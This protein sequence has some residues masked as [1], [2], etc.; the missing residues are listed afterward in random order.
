VDRRIAILPTLL[1]LGNAVCGLAAIAYV[2]KVGPTPEATDAWYFTLGAYLILAAMVFDALDGAVARL[3]RTSTPFGA[4]LDSLCDAISFG[5]APA[6]LLLRLGLEWEK[7]LIRQGVA[8][9]AALYMACAILRLARFNIESALEAKR[10]RGQTT[11]GEEPA[12]VNQPKRFKGLPSPAAAGCVAS[13]AVLRAE[14]GTEWFGLSAEYLHAFAKVW[15]PLGTLLVALLMVS[16]IPYPHFTKR[17]LQKKRPF[18][19]VV[20]AVFA[21]FIIALA[22]HLAFIL[23]FWAYALAGPARELFVRGVR[24]AQFHHH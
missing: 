11:G 14:L 4:Q 24:L 7:P 20:Q 18:S 6:F 15:A 1:T 5:A 22:P 3:S 17:L 10:P 12:P 21:I 9:V 2:S 16:R 8:A 19:V 13:L 23:L